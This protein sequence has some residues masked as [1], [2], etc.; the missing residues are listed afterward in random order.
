[1]PRYQAGA[2]DGLR[3][4]DPAVGRAFAPITVLAEGTAASHRSQ[5]PAHGSGGR[6]AHGSGGLT[7]M[8]GKDRGAELPRRVPGAAPAGPP[9]PVP[10][11]APALS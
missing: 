4:S 11:A 8:A 7:R 2:I 6:P 9:S 5:R 10:P 1:M 3:A